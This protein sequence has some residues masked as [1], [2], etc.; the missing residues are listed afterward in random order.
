MHCVEAKNRLSL[1]L[2]MI[3]SM[4][5]PIYNHFQATWANRG[6]ITTSVKLSAHRSSTAD[7]HCHSRVPHTHC[8][9]TVGRSRTP[10][11][12]WY[13]R[14]SACS[15]WEGVLA[16]RR[17]G[18]R[19][20]QC[21]SFRIVGKLRGN[22]FIANQ[23][24]AASHSPSHYTLLAPCI[25]PWPTHYNKIV[26]HNLRVSLRFNKYFFVILMHFVLFV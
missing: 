25:L 20:G 22:L 15:S 4:S 8:G 21:C 3:S 12:R 10:P 18:K 19:T 16:Y 11:R 2:V 23:S 17:H 7:D 24:R 6:K 5:V 1:V 14:W 9:T 26:P 13:R